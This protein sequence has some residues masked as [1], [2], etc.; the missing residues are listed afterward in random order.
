[1]S[2]V[3]HRH[4]K[5]EPIEQA[6]CESQIGPEQQQ[7]QAGSTEFLEALIHHGNSKKQGSAFLEKLYEI[8]MNEEYESF[9]SWCA[10]GKSI[11]IKKVEDF[12]QVHVVYNMV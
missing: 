8:L 1:M 2:G 12:S 10:D 5:S 4:V 3:D 11:L 9:I 7:Q 6:F